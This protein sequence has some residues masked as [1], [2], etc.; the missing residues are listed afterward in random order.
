MKFGTAFTYRLISYET[1][2]WSL[3]LKVLPPKACHGPRLS[4]G[5]NKPQHTPPGESQGRV[6][7]LRLCE[8]TV[9]NLLNSFLNQGFQNT[10]IDHGTLFPIYCFLTSQ[11]TI[12]QNANIHCAFFKNSKTSVKTNGKNY[13]A[14]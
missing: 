1:V 14:G 6:A 8:I 4:K 5:I 9:K 2:L 11:G 12:L 10:F 3:A 7:Y 13:V